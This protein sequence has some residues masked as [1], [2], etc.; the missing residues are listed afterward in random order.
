MKWIGVLPL[1]PIVSPFSTRL[2]VPS[3]GWCPAAHLV[4][5]LEDERV[6]IVDVNATVVQG[7]NVMRRALVLHLHKR[8]T[9]DDDHARTERADWAY[10][11]G[12]LTESTQGSTN[13][14]QFAF[15]IQ[16]AQSQERHSGGGIV[17]ICETGFNWGTSS[18]AWLCASPATRVFSFDLDQGY[19]TS[20]IHGRPYIHEAAAWL[21]RRF[22]GR[23]TLTLGDSFRTV[24]GFVRQHKRQPLC[25]IILADGG[26]D[27][28][29]AYADMRNLRCVAKRNAL[30][31]ADDCDPEPPGLRAQKLGVHIAYTRMR[32][33]GFLRHRSAHNF[34]SRLCCLSDVQST[35][36]RQRTGY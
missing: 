22:P 10:R 19:K 6:A 17:N 27:A 3:G 2:R 31:L 33:E 11:E 32:E 12:G 29:N 26:H 18:L 8:L 7:C 1:L 21:Q 35:G 28:A 30:L 15:L 36:A 14:K 4:P 24:P 34:S 16:L 25:D 5:P 9:K 20:T 23:L 13:L